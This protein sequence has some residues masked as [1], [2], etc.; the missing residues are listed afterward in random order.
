MS[1]HG[2]RGWQ[3]VM[4]ATLR[5]LLLLCKLH[6]PCRSWIVNCH[7][8]KMEHRDGDFGWSIE[9]ATLG[10]SRRLCPGGGITETAASLQTDRENRAAGGEHP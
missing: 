1:G 8:W 10:V 2:S 4:G 7:K 3:M 6:V 5:P 9:M